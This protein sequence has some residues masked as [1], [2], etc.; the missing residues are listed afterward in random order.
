MIT[1]P[2]LAASDVALCHFPPAF[3]SLR[4]STL[5]PSLA[6]SDVAFSLLPHFLHPDAPFVGQGDANVS[7]VVPIGRG[8]NVCV[9]QYNR[10]LVC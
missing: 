6:A 9:R 5:V 7:G 3:P 1:V 8:H 10:F 4:A 2:S